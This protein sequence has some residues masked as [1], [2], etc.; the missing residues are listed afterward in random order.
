MLKI[1]DYL[2]ITAGFAGIFLFYLIF[3]GGLQID[4]GTEETLPVIEWEEPEEKPQP[5]TAQYV[6]LYGNEKG[7][8]LSCQIMQ[9]LD[10]LKKEYLAKGT[11]EELSERQKEEAEVFIITTGSLEEAD[12]E[13]E[14]LSLIRDDGKRAFY[15]ILSGEN[16]EYEQELGILK[17]R[18]ETEIDGMMI[19]DGLLVQGM[20]YYADLPM[21]VRDVSLEA[22]CTKL[23]QEQSRTIKE[24]RNLIPLLWKKQYGN[25]KIYSCNGPFFES[26]SDIGIFAGVLFDMEETFLY[27]VVNS[28]AVL[29]DYYPD[30]EH[31]DAQTIYEL[32]SRDPIAYIRDVIWPAIDKVG[33]ESDLVISGRS[34]MKNKDDDFYDIQRQMQRNKGIVME[35]GEGTILPIIS[36]GHSQSDEKRYRMES[37]ASGWGIASC[38][39]DMRE[40][41]GSKGNLEEFEWAAYSNELTKNIYDIYRNNQFLESVN[42]LEAQERLKR[43]ERIAP[44]FEVTDDHIQIRADGFVDV[45]YCMVR[46]D[47]NLEDGQGYEMQ[48]VGEDAYL[49][50]IERQEITIT[51]Q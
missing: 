29:L 30:P 28:R 45:W 26:E 1:S 34:Y 13:Y 10:K 24:Q 35:E 20:V 33:H 17:S 12:E 43:Y 22:A 37:A 32:Y 16:A 18:G 2:A 19:F 47:R 6:V 42:W 44:V 8:E 11:M 38:Y 39:L 48:K 31:A 15:T 5:E 41:M 23:I 40:V 21:E 3:S 50:Q 7:S 51:M 27:P 25:G 49:L 46:T 4:Y 9:M 14:L 36:E